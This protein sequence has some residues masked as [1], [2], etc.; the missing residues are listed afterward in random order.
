MQVLRRDVR[1]L[2]GVVLTEDGVEKVVDFGQAK[3]AGES[4]LTQLGSSP[5][6]PAYMSPEQIQGA[7]DED[8]HAVPLVP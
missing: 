6:T 3:L 1:A 7:E 2:P 5:G 8:G 4:R